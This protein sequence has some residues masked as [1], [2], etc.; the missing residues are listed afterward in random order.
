M[1]WPD[2]RSP[3]NDRAP[4]NP[5]CKAQADFRMR[6]FVAT[7]VIDV[8]MASPRLAP[9][10]YASHKFLHRWTTPQRC[11]N[12]GAST[13]TSYRGGFLF[14]LLWRKSSTWNAHDHSGSPIFQSRVSELEVTKRT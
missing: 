12:S 2:T 8:T 5:Y 7:L 9:T 11:H 1:G 3:V 13:T 6:V 10:Y 4:T 14:E